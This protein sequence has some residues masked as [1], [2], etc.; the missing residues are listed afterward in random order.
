MNPHNDLVKKALV[1][2]TDIGALAFEIK[3]YKGK[4]AKGFFV[5][6]GVY[7][8]ASD[9]VAI[10]NGRVLWLEAKTGCGRQT[11]EQKI[12]EREITQHGGEYFVFRSVDE[13]RLIVDR[14]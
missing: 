9:I 12:F 8:G 10:H 5:D 11:R 6:A 14:V 7:A 1:Y 4:T 2:L 3:P 13:V